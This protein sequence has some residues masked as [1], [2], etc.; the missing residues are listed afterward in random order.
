MRVWFDGNQSDAYVAD[1]PLASSHVDQQ[2]QTLLKQA[3]HGVAG[4]NGP[5]FVK[6]IAPTPGYSLPRMAAG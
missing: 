4:L 6:I 5:F 1:D 3:H 2:G